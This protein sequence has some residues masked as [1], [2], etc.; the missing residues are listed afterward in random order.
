MKKEQ[1]E[2]KEEEEEV[3]RKSEIFKNSICIFKYALSPRCRSYNDLGFY[4]IL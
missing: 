1:E 2:G 3:G 4:H